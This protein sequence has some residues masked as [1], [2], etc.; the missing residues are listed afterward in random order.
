M[1]DGRREGKRERGEK[2]GKTEGGRGKD[3]RAER[4]R[5]GLAG[6]RTVE[7]RGQQEHDYQGQRFTQKRVKAALPP[8]RLW[9][10]SYAP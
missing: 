3:G 10:L 9:C 8:S 1:A 7:Q 5:R 2:G 6:L 4:R